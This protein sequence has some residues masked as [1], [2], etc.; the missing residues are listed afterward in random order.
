MIAQTQFNVLLHS[1]PHIGEKALGRLLRVLA[2][3]GESPDEFL[4]CDAQVLREQY[5]LDPR[6]AVFLWEH[7]D[8]LI[9][10]SARFLRLTSAL[11]LR[12]VSINDAVYPRRLDLYDD[13]PPPL[14]YAFGRLAMLDTDERSDFTFALSVSNG[15]GS[16]SLALLDRTAKTLV[17]LG[18]IPVTGH[19]RAPYQRAGLAAQR[20]GRP[21][22]YVLDRGL[23]EAL[24]PALD[25]PP[26]AAARIRDAAFEA[27]RDL[28][29][30]PFRMDDH[31]IG[32]N[33]RRRDR[34][35]HA[36]ADLIVA[37]DVRAGG[38]MYAECRRASEQGRAV[39]VATG[40]RDGNDAL[41]AAGC[42]VLPDDLS[43]VRRYFAGPR[44]AH[45]G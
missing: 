44:G 35:V 13:A 16:A 10:A 2:Q 4:S 15:V 5:G 43:G 29:L 6:S 34:I 25:R 1:V 32:A 40:G 37:I 12:V 24:G 42:A 19:D 21:A 22:I 8:D 33:N 45:A 27:Q 36:L 41:R 7:R 28:V 11:P 26:F 30:S 31:S 14:L 17:E 3:R 23:Y 9:A 38:A 18:G 39:L 20:T